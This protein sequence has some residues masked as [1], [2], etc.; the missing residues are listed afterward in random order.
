MI[1]PRRDIPINGTHLVARLIFAHLLEIHSL[2]LENAVKLPSQRLAHETRGAQFNLAYFFEDFA[3]D[4]GTG[5]SL[6]ILLMTVSLFFSSASAS[7]VTV[8]RWRRTSMP[9]VLTS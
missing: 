9:M 7:Y 3:R 6:K 1:H 8:T 5:N 4:H 2:P